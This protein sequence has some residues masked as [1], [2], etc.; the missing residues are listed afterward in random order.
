MS[1][2]ASVRMCTEPKSKENEKERNVTMAPLANW[3]VPYI[4]SAEVRCN[5]STTRTEESTRHVSGARTL[6]SK[7][8]GPPYNIVGMPTWITA[9]I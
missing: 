7:S 4:L 2:R 9:K 6:L 1:V 8:E 5:R 3:R